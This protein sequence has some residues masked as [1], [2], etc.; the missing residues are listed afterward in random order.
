MQRNLDKCGSV[1]SDA[2]ILAKPITRATCACICMCA[3]ACVHACVCFGVCM[4]ACACLCVCACEC[5]CACACLW[6]FV[7]V[8]LCICVCV[9]MRVCV[10]VCVCARMCVLTCMCAL[11]PHRHCSGVRD[12]V[13]EHPLLK[14]REASSRPH[15]G[16]FAKNARLSSQSCV[17]WKLCRNQS[18]RDFPR[19]PSNDEDDQDA[20]NG[21]QV[22]GFLWL[23][24]EWVTR[25]CHRYWSSSKSF[26]D[27]HC[28]QNTTR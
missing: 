1:A 14:Q 13:L 16:G 23:R 2:E 4:C 6:V 7:R 17:S 27:A 28:N 19:V 26:F 25:S 9:R 21:S 10:R 3:C 20:P 24:R 11:L 15:E 5:V 18:L 22:S 12:A 8:C